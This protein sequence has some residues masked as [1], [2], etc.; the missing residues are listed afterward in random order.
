MYTPR[1]QTAVHACYLSDNYNSCF[2]RSSFF[3]CYGSNVSIRQEKPLCYGWNCSM[4]GS[5]EPC[6]QDIMLR[7]RYEG[8]KMFRRGILWGEMPLTFCL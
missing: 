5:N 2:A 8:R 6:D 4:Q 3:L 7:L 1:A